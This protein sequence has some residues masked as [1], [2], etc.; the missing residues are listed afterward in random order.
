M[1]K[2][3]TSCFLSLTAKRNLLAQSETDSRVCVQDSV[4]E[5]YLDIYK[6]QWDVTAVSLLFRLSG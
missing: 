4:L 6:Q 5:P 3:S 2:A 1:Y